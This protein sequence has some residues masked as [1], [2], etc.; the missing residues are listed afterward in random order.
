MRV[1]TTFGRLVVLDIP[2]RRAGRKIIL[3]GLRFCTNRKRAPSGWACTSSMVRP[4][5]AANF[6]SIGS[7][8]VS[9]KSRF[10]APPWAS[11]DTG[12]T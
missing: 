3:R 1:I 8:P 4:R 9:R 7:A 2:D 12:R 10:R 11:S 5:P 6:M